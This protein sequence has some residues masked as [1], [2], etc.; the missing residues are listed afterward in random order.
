[1]RILEEILLNSKY[2]PS[3]YLNYLRI[4]L[5]KN[6]KI[7]SSVMKGKGKDSGAVEWQQTL[8]KLEEVRLALARNLARALVSGSDGP[9]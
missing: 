9:F 6:K 1:M 7:M 4:Y 2:N 5:D 3:S 8:L